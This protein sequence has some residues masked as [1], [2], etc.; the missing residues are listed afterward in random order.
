MSRKNVVV[1]G[2]ATCKAYQQA[3]DALLGM[4][5]LYPNEWTVEVKECK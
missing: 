3:R 5:A 2:Y 1:S 4:K